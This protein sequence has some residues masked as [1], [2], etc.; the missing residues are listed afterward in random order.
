MH[1]KHHKPA[2]IVCLD[3][4]ETRDLVRAEAGECPRCH[5]LGWTYADE[6]DDSCLRRQI[7]DRALSRRSPVAPLRR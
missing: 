5:Y 2:Q 3:C 1:R 7:I 4:G 6:I